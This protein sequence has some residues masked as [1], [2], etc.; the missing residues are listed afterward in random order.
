L[1]VRVNMIRLGL[2]RVAKVVR[3]R[4]RGRLEHNGRDSWNMMSHRFEELYPALRLYE[5][6]L[7]FGFGVEGTS[8][9]IPRGEE[10]TSPV[11]CPEQTTD[12]VQVD[13]V[14]DPL[15]LRAPHEQLIQPEPPG[16]HQAPG[17]SSVLF[18]PKIFHS[19]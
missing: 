14:G 18:G 13:Q 12:P 1:G 2:K 19:L 11:D 16:Q 10:T 8:L 17:I 15:S 9:D 6:A 3:G 5:A 7:T 4:C